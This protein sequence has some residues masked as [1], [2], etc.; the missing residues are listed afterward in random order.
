M[1]RL[2]VVLAVLPR[3]VRDIVRAQLEA[4][5]SWAGLA[6][7]VVGE[8]AT[9]EALAPL[10]RETHPSLVVVGVASDPERAEVAGLLGL[11]EGLLVLAITD[12]GRAVRL[13]GMVSREV[14]PT[15]AGF[16]AVLTELAGSALS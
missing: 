8:T 12:G 11:R 7:D 5:A 1:E 2:R 6:V 16:G 3:M 9:L 15:A 4:G 10:V 13:H 14:E